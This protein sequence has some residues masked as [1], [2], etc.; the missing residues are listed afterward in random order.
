MNFHLIPKQ[1]YFNHGFI[2]KFDEEFKLFCKEKGVNPNLLN[3][4]N[5]R[6][7]DID[8]FENFRKYFLWRN[9]SH[10]DILIGEIKTNLLIPDNKTEV[11][12]QLIILES[13]KNQIESWTNK[14]KYEQETISKKPNQKLKNYTYDLYFQYCKQYKK[15]YNE[16]LSFTK[17]NHPDLDFEN[18]KFYTNL[19]NTTKPQSTIENSPLLTQKEV[20]SY[21][22][23]SA[24]QVRNLEDNKHINRCATVGRSPR[25]L[26]SEIEN[27][28]NSTGIKKD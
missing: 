6:E 1:I 15:L 21:L 17:Q 23:V 27:Y 16:L 10:L 22:K 5:M 14:I 8:K 9:K 20:A 28:L 26:K 19:E 18:Q 4:T 7:R 11:Q 24:R 12:R 2:K 3:S 25:Y 13:L